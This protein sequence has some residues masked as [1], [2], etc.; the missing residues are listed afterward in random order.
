M[1]QIEIITLKEHDSWPKT[2]K[3]KETAAQLSSGFTNSDDKLINFLKDKEILTIRKLEKAGLEIETKQFIGSVR[4]SNF[5][6]KILPKFFSDND[7]NWKNLI[8]CIHFAYDY[9]TDHFIEYEKI[10]FEDENENYDLVDFIVWGL[11]NECNNLIKRGLLKSYVEHEENMPYLKGKLV[12]KHQI[13][14]DM[15]KKLQFYCEYDELEF[16]NI[17]NRILLDTLILCEKIVKSNTLKRHLFIQIQQL[18]R[19]VQKIPISISDIERVMNSYNM[20]NLHYKNAHSLCKLIKEN[21]S[22]SDIYEGNTSFAIPFFLDMNKIFEDFVTKL[23]QEYYSGLF[24]DVQIRKRAWVYGNKKHD[25]IPDLLLTDENK[26]IK[27]IIDV[28]YKDELLISDLYQIGFYISEYSFK[29][30]FGEEA[31]AILPEF[32]GTTRVDKYTATESQIKINV[33]YIS[34]LDIIE[35]IKNDDSKIPDLL[36]SLLDKPV[37]FT[38]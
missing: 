32:E 38:T 13:V 15:H 27:K 26:K 6:L 3:E 21:V 8:S 23:L 31:F 9:D 30:K 22:I 18:N 17:E 14:N 33:R 19:L 10:P 24:V 5:H 35:Q 37:L 36:S 28:K 12:I 7:K 1:N 34:I 4:F 16:D 29:Y 11:V 25:M 20:Q 2:E